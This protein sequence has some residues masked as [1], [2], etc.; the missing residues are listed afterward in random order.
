VGVPNHL[1]MEMLK[2]A[3]GRRVTHVPYKGAAASITALIA[4]ELTMM[5]E[6][7]AA[8]IPHIKGGRLNVLAVGSPTRAQSLPDL[9]TVAE[10]G[11][12]DYGAQGWSSLVTPAGTPLAVVHKLHAQLKAA[13]ALPEMRKRLQDLGVEPVDFTLERTNAFFRTELENWARTVK[14]SGAKAD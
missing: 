2:S 11:N 5:F 14:A 7:A 4:G 12:P 10:A 9:P 13:L 8:V 1:M 3:T 6:T